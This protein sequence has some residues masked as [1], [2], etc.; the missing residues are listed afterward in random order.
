MQTFESEPRHKITKEQERIEWIVGVEGENDDGDGS[1]W[2]FSISMY[3]Y[4][5]LHGILRNETATKNS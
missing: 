3:K 5:Y 1:A 4:M 2:S